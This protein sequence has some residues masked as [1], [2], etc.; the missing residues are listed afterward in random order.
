M[1]RTKYQMGWSFVLQ[2]I[3]RALGDSG[4][5]VGYRALGTFTIVRR[6]RVHT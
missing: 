5:E 2:P 3:A 1:A 6:Q 4:S